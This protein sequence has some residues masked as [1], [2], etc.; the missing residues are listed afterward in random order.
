[1]SG[2][3]SGVA[4]GILTFK[5]FETDFRYTT[6]H[7]SKINSLTVGLEQLGS[8]V[9]C[10]FIYPLANKYGRKYT[11][12]GSSAVFVLGALLETINTRSLG[13]WY[14][15]RIIAGLGMGGLSVVVPMYSAEMTPKEIRGRCGSFYQ[16]MYTWGVF[17]AYWV[18]Y[19]CPLSPQS[20]KLLTDDSDRALPPIPVSP[21][22]L[23]SG[24]SL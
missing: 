14:T 22:S 4:G 13:A 15:A 17:T 2:Y 11:I 5:P 20:I 8:F 1:M 10:F 23:V 12:I 7:E 18:D 24:R 9:A 19:V 21:K 6:A 3:D 16:W